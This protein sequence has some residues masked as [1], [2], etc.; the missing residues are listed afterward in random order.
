MKEGD[1]RGAVP[2][3]VNGSAQE[4]VGLTVRA[5]RTIDRCNLDADVVPFVYV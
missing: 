2:Q 4:L 1:G 3:R 5:R